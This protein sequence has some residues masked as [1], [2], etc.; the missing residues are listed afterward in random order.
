VA[1]DLIQQLQGLQRAQDNILRVWVGYEIARGQLDLALGTM[2]IDD[3]GMWIDPGPIG[4]KHGYP[5]NEVK[6]DDEEGKK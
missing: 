5:Q 4:Y 3:E 1:R 6:G 2:Q